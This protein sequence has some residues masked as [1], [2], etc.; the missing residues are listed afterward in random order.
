MFVFEIIFW[1]LEYVCEWLLTN[2]L[3]W[4]DTF[5]HLPT[6]HAD[7]I[8]I[9]TEGITKVSRSSAENNFC[10]QWNRVRSRL[11]IVVFSRSLWQIHQ[12][13][14]VRLKIIWKRKPCQSTSCSACSICNAFLWFWLPP[15]QVL[16]QKGE[17]HRPPFSK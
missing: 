3:R 11:L 14:F 6:L 2:V 9:F 5:H 16:S 12:N 13:T 7:T 4:V 10:H 8:I 15:W 17:T 1:W